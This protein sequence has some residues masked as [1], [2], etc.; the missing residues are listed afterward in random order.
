VPVRSGSEPY[1]K[2]VN[3]R[4]FVEPVVIGPIWKRTLHI[5]LFS[6]GPVPRTGYP[7]FVWETNPTYLNRNFDIMQFNKYSV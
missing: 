7:W 4:I 3:N 5:I 6:V 2:S 1:I